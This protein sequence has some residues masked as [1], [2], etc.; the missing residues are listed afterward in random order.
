MATIE[1]RG[2]SATGKPRVRPAAG[3]AKG[4]RTR[5]ARVGASVLVDPVTRARMIAEA[6]YYKA[7]SRGFAPGSDQLDWFEAEREIEARFPSAG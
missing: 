2:G 4:R 1:A 6:A 7:E 5:S 3:V